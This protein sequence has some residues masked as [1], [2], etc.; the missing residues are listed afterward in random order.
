MTAGREEP[1][2]MAIGAPAMPVK[3]SRDQRQ[4]ESAGKRAVHCAMYTLGIYI[5]NNCTT[6]SPCF[7]NDA[8]ITNVHSKCAY[9]CFKAWVFVKDIG[10]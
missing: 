10:C 7:K 3:S 6:F 1:I 4:S 2:K 5:H 8:C 9:Q